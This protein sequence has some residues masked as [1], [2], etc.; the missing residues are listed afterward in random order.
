MLRCLYGGSSNH[1]PRA[2]KH[3]LDTRLSPTFQEDFCR[4]R[5]P[6][7]IAN[8]PEGWYGINSLSDT[9]YRYSQTSVARLPLYFL[10]NPILSLA[11]AIRRITRLWG[12]TH[13]CGCSIFHI[14]PYIWPS[15]HLGHTPGLAGAL[16]S[17]YMLSVIYYFLRCTYRI[18]E[19]SLDSW[20]FTM[21][22]YFLRLNVKTV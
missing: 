9:L 22:F 7:I 5:Y 2:E 8:I 10:T 19:R 21:Y 20:T 13:E 14:W 11:G 6:T 12:C 4:Y 17:D 3:G 16:Y 18:N 1:K 15:Y